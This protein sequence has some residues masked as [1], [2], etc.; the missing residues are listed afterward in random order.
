MP[1]KLYKKTGNFSSPKGEYRFFLELG[2]E[3]Q[4][5]TDNLYRFLSKKNTQKT[6]KNIQNFPIANGTGWIFGGYLFLLGSPLFLHRHSRCTAPAFGISDAQQVN[7]FGQIPQ[8]D[9]I[10][11]MNDCHKTAYGIIDLHLIR[12]KA[13]DMHPVSSGIGIN[14]YLGNVLVLA[15][16]YT[17]LFDEIRKLRP[18]LSILVGVKRSNG[19][20]DWNVA[21][22]LLKSLIP[23]RW[24]NRGIDRHLL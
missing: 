22:H 13:L 9:L 24:R 7:A 14:E 19:N 4:L 10:C 1:A 12:L 21:V 23:N 3:N 16:P 11:F 2:V 17:F 15:N 20:V 5:I 6:T 8:T 18:I